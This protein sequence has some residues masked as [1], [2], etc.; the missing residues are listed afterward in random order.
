[1]SHGAAEVTIRLEVH[2]VYTEEDGPWTAVEPWQ[3][4]GPRHGSIPHWN[5]GGSEM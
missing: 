4:N 5:Q 3:W 2:E 1:M